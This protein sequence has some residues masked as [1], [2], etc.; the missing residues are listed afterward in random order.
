[1]SDPKEPY[2][3]ESGD[4]TPPQEPAATPPP[5]ADAPAAKPRLFDIPLPPP[6]QPKGKIEAPELLS[7]FEEDA[8]F[9]KDPELE[10]VISG[11]SGKP[12]D[13][14]KD[15]KPPAD[16][17]VQPGLGSAKVWAIVGVTLLVVAM[18][19]TG[20]HAGPASERILNVLLVL[21]RTLVH[22]GTGVVAV[23]VAA[24]LL[25]K[26][27]GNFELAGA[28]ML[29]AVGA[30]SAMLS[31]QFSLF[32]RVWLDNLIALIM[33]AA[34][35]VLL[36]AS[37]FNLWKKQPLSFVIGSHFFLWLIVAVGMLLA[38]V[39]RP[40]KAP[41]AAPAVKTPASTPKVPPPTG[42]T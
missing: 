27:L 31:F 8:D 42:P 38:Q 9:D 19:A 30:F 41:A 6:S 3:V 33:A 25:G 12:A 11:K 26:K 16:D 29:A 5:R 21:Y 17:F 18:I 37:T 34:V 36:V 39:A 35:Y 15:P 4:S 14:S 28:R 2:S 22:T 20:V 7:G 1:M 10:R 32:G 40:D 13:V 23:F 24:T